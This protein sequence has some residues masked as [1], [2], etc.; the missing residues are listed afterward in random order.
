MALQPGQAAFQRAQP[1]LGFARR[2]SSRPAG[3][4]PEV[5]KKSAAAAAT[6][7]R[8]LIVEDEIFV[9]LNAASLLEDAGYEVAAMVGTAELAVAKAEELAPDLVLMDISLAGERD[10]IDAAVEIHR[11]LGIRSLFVTA[12]QD[13]ETR[14][15]AAAA[16]PIG[17]VTKP[18]A[19]QDLAGP[20]EAYFKSR[21]N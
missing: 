14:A 2:P 21:A 18:F 17:Y 13:N 5:G 10:G 11:T 4:A 3:R 19:K 9:A 15:R 20:L 12:F 1:D 7:R 16:E 8:V 6:G